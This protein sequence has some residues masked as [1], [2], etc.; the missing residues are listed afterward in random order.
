MNGVRRFVMIS[1]DK[2]V[3]PTN[4]MGASKRI[5]EMIIQTFNRR[6]DTEFVGGPL[7]QC[8]WK[9]RQCD[10]AV[11]R[12]RLRQE[13]CYGN[14]PQYHPL[15]HNDPGSSFPGTAGRSLCKGR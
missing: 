10:S 15:L 5:C 1:T 14:R 12:S 7:R 2:A 8:S 13:D 3:N 4:I 6:Y 9:Q 11:L